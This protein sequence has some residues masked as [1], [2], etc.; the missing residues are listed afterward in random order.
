[1]P[2]PA[3]AAAAA[4]W[5]ASHA[6]DAAAAVPVSSFKGVEY[7]P[8]EKK[9]QAY[10]LDKAISE[11]SGGTCGHVCVAWGWAL[12]DGCCLCRTLML[13]PLMPAKQ[14]VLASAVMKT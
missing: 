10:V 14:H 13:L 12:Q 4:A 8:A 2:D 5:A 6:A 3:A 9:W 7:L 1:V 11:V